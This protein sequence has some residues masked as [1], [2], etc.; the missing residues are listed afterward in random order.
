MNRLPPIPF[1]LALALA[2]ASG[3]ASLAPADPSVAAPHASAR[4]GAPAPADAEPTVIPAA[5]L[6]GPIAADGP[7]TSAKT[8]AAGKPEATARPGTSARRAATARSGA[9]P[10]PQARAAEPSTTAPRPASSARAGTAASDDPGPSVTTYVYTDAPAPRRREAA[11][12][13][14]P[15]AVA[16]RVPEGFNPYRIPFVPGAYHCELG[17]SVDVRTVSADLRTTVLR[18]GREEYTLRAVEARSGALRYEDP[19]SGLAW[20]VLRDR[21]M[22]LDARAGQRLANACRV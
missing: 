21:S 8:A 15:R 9:R 17:R 4:T 6:L 18:W 20:I 10:A 3:C 1:A 16:G 12:H 14:A 22:L 11:A 13:A 5:A 2:G 7:D 19:A